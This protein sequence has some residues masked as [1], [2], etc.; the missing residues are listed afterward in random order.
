MSKV[1]STVASI[2][3]A[4]IIEQLP[5]QHK[6]WADKLMKLSPDDFGLA[7]LVLMSNKTPILNLRALINKLKDRENRPA[8]FV[9]LDERTDEGDFS[10]HERVAAADPAAITYQQCVVFDQATEAVLGIARTT[11]KAAAQAAGCSLRAAK[12]KKKQL[13][14]EYAGKTV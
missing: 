6:V 1:T 4:E 2:H 11:A 3:R 5:A 14:K 10:L 13:I 12:Y 9:S 7:F 8:G